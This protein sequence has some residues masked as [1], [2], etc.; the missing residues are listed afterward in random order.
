M[1]HIRTNTTKYS[2]N[3]KSYLLVEFNDFAIP[4]NMDGALHDLQ[5]LGLSPVITHPERNRLIRTQPERLKGWLRQGCYVQITAQSFLGGFGETA[6][7][8]AEEWL[9]QEMVHFVASDTQTSHAGL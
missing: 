2:I 7:K 6:R 4:P 3:Q 8:R 1:Q 5:L 9:D